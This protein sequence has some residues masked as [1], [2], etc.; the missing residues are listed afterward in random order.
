MTIEWSLAAIQD[1]IAEAVPTREMLVWTDVRRTWGEVAE[2]SKGLAGFLLDRSIGLRHER[3]GLERW[4]CGQVPVALVMHNRPEYLESMLA[5]YRARAVP[6]NVNHQYN[7]AEIGDLFAMIG[8]GAV[9]YQ[10]SLGLLIAE[11]AAGLEVVLIDIDDGSGAEPLADS[12]DYSAAIEAGRGTRLPT[13]SGDDL[14]LVCTGGTTGAPKGV[15]WRQADIFV[16]AMGGS[17]DTT[18]ESLVAAATGDS[19]VWFAAPPFMH[20]AAQ[21]TAFAGLHVGATVVM[22]DDS[23]RF[24]ATEILTVA[25]REH[26]N[27]MSIVGDAYARPLVEELRRGSY[28]LAS[29]RRIGTGGAMT[30][31]E[32]KEALLDLLPDVTVVDG[33]GASETGGMA[34]GAMSR[35]FKMAGLAGAAG[36]VVLTA[37][38]SRMLE[39]GDEEIGW[40]ARRGRV[41]LGYLNDQEATER[42]FPVLDGERLSVP[43]D[44]GQLDA[45]GSIRMLGRDAMVVNTGGEKVFVEEV[46]QALL[47]HPD[48][49]DVLVVGRPSSRFGQEVVAVVQLAPGAE[50]GGEDLREFSALSIARFKAPRAFV[51][52]EMIRRHPTGKPDYQWAKAV[53]E[54]AVAIV[55]SGPSI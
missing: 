5:C 30:S 53:A 45:D 43:G 36:A 52:T 55:D 48:V 34:F 10:R 16:A 23:K 29:L 51:F 28:D 12:V 8:A 46:E 37:D 3:E 54:R 13:P 44:R 32:N 42:T 21:W 1:V 4:E 11:A 35:T 49:V 14:Y 7:S 31:M 33:Y 6:F 9:I 22:H 47:R 40:I 38:R 2:R 19:Q 15:L 27:L 25:E 24:D 20:A 39:P 17:E 26:V 50:I 41:P 18:A